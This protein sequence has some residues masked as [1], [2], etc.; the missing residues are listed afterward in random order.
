MALLCKESNH[1]TLSDWTLLCFKLKPACPGSAYET[2]TEL[3][4]S[5]VFLRETTAYRDV[6]GYRMSHKI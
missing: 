3:Q 5:I 4:S 1:Y 2:E 6:H